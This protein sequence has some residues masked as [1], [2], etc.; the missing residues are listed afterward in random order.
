MRHMFRVGLQ[1]AL[2]WEGR[3]KNAAQRAREARLRARAM[4]GRMGGRVWGW[5]MF[6]RSRKSGEAGKGKGVAERMKDVG[7]G[8]K[9]LEGLMEEEGKG[10]V[11]R[12]EGRNAGVKEGY[13]EERNAMNVEKENK[14]F[15]GAVRDGRR[16]RRVDLEEENGA[17]KSKQAH[18]R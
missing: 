9:G 2:R 6:G 7:K 1:I 17:G 15:E 3:A 5:G 14:S 11:R 18:M 13:R 16:Q 10:V 12:R 4:R 8:S